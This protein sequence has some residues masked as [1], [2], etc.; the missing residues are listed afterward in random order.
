MNTYKPIL[1][2]ETVSLVISTKRKFYKIW[3]N[4]YLLKVNN[5]N[6]WKRVWNMFKVNNKST[7]EIILLFLLLTSNMFHTFQMFLLLTLNK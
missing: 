1:E 4:I 6:I 3:A 5:R 7:T 2:I